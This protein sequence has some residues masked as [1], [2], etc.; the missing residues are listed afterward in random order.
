MKTA[1]GTALTKVA[2]LVLMLVVVGLITMGPASAHHR[3]DHRQGPKPTASPTPEPTPTAEP[4][5]TVHDVVDVV[6]GVGEVAT[7]PFRIF[8][9]GSSLWDVWT[10]LFG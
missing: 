7:C 2:A 9:P 6:E 10:C 8:A 4:D 5:P 1:N 3:P